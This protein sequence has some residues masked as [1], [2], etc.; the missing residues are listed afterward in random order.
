MRLLISY[1]LSWVGSGEQTHT[2]FINQLSRRTSGRSFF[3]GSLRAS[4]RP[5]ATGQDGTGRDGNRKE[6]RVYGNVQYILYEF[7]RIYNIHMYT[8]T[9][10]YTYACMLC[11][12]TA[13]AQCRVQIRAF[14]WP[15]ESDSSDESEWPVQEPAAFILLPP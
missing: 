4:G 8:C 11:V 2:R 7:M 5:C 15:K 3:D 6:S 9:V 10:L 12:F 14:D 13:I 1:Y